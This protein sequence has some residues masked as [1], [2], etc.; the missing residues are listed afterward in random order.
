MSEISDL[1]QRVE[2]VG[3]KFGRLAEQVSSYGERLTDLLTAVEEGFARSQKETRNLNSDLESAQDEVKK[4]TGER[5]A[6]KEE[7]RQ[8]IR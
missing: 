6:A 7:T 3:A 5:D 8:R 2:A 1:K 4:L